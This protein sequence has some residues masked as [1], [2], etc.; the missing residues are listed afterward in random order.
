MTFW[1]FCAPF[2]DRAERENGGAYGDMIHLIRGLVTS[3]A[4]VFEAAAGT[5]A[6]GLALA[7]KAGSVRC[8]DLSKPMLKAARK[9]AERRGLRNI[10]FAEKSI[11]NTGEPDGACDVVIA[12]QVLHLIDDPEK[13]A[14]ELLRISRGLVIA[15]VGLLREVQGLFIRLNV[16][17][18]RLLGF[19]PKREFDTDGYYEFLVDIGLAPE[20]FEVIGGTMPLAVPVVRK[21]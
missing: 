13:A 16:G 12:S 11:F 19:A 1:D 9:K 18:W 8:T 21:G 7:D 3:G 5:G 14:A 20:H 4:A 17:I 15:P 6:I 2:Y 10:S